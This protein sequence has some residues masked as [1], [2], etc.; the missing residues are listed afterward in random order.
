MSF[1]VNV[2]STPNSFWW[3]ADHLNEH[4]ARVDSFDA[5]SGV[6][7]QFTGFKDKETDYYEDDLISNNL[8]TDK[9]TIRQ[10]KLIDGCWMLSRVKGKSTLPKNLLLHDMAGL[11][12]PIVGNIHSNP[13][14]LKEPT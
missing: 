10:V 3:S 12:W 8:G 14:L 4:G 9:E 2:Y 5:E 11:N 1:N 13:E 7:M 6:L